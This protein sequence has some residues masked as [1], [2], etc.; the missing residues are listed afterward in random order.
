MYPG[1]GCPP[2]P[3]GGYGCPPPPPM[4]GYGCPPPPPMGGYGCPPPMGGYGYPG[5]MLPPGYMPYTPGMAIPFGYKLSKRGYLKPI[6]A[7]NPYK[8]AKKMY[9]H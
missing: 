2:P 6:H 8:L 9:R 3:M 4:G 1:Y 5:G 7:K